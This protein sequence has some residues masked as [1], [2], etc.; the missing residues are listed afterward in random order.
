[1]L[2]DSTEGYDRGE[3]FEHYRKLESLSEYVLIAQNRHHIE[4]YHRQ[5]DDQWLLTV[6]D[7]PQEI[8]QL[9]SI[10]CS[11]VLAEVYDKVEI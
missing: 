6:T 8:I 7:K 4:Y 1:M 2:S 5:A 10:D 3:K 11:L 9:R